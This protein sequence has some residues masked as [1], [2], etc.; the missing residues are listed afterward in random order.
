M[1]FQELGSQRLYADARSP[2]TDG[3]QWVGPQTDLDQE[4]I[5]TVLPPTL[6]KMVNGYD[7]A[8]LEDDDSVEQRE[9]VEPPPESRQR[10]KRP[11]KTVNRREIVS[12]LVEIAGMMALSYGFWLKWPWVGVICSGLCL[13]LVGVALSRN[14]EPESS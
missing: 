2:Q 13:I 5:P 14:V 11:R 9:D 7:T 8:P 12:I 10:A 6:D 4:E 3:G 1:T